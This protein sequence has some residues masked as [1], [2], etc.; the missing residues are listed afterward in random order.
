MPSARKIYAYLKLFNSKHI[1]SR[2]NLVNKINMLSLF[3]H[4]VMTDSLQP[5]G[6]QHTR[7]LC[8]PLSLGV[9]SNSCPLSQWFY[10]T[11]SSSATPFSFCL[12][13][14][15]A[16]E[17]FPM[18]QLFVSGGQSIRASASASVLP[19]NIWDWFPLGLTGLIFAVQ[20]TLKSLLQDLSSQTSIVQHSAFMMV[21]LIND[22]WKND[23][24][25]Y[26]DPY[27]QSD[28]LL[29]NNLS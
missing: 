22:L 20:R 9:Y 1:P 6:L 10:Q 15:P 25:Y 5:H 13:S 11:I 14:F 17:S 8:P 2:I 28:F 4:P 19:M 12:K 26:M 27:W 3:S 7:L 29:L 23:S 18:S 21:Q 16:T 24:C